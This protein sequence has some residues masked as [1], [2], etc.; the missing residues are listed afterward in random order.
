MV[1]RAVTKRAQPSY[2][3]QLQPTQISVDEISLAVVEQ[4]TLLQDF[5]DGTITY[6]GNCQENLPHGKG[7]L[8][9]DG[10]V[11]KGH[12]NEGRLDNIESLNKRVA[13]QAKQSQMMTVTIL[14]NDTRVYI[15]E[16]SG[17]EPHGQ[18]KLVARTG[19][20]FEGKFK[21]GKLY[22]GEGKCFDSDGQQ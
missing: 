12:W 2:L 14:V 17:D 20:T 16:V 22:D 18:G 15:G 13:K 7:E 6:T 10:Q 8:K 11:Y 3:S 21:D 9:L 1:D 5:K 19:S 4:P